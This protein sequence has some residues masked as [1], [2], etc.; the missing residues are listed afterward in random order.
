MKTLMPTLD[1][2]NANISLKHVPELNKIRSYASQFS[3]A[4]AIN[5][6]KFTSGTFAGVTTIII[7]E[8]YTENGETKM[9]LDEVT[10]FNS[11][12]FTLTLGF[13]ASGILGQNI[14]SRRTM[15]I[16]AIT[17][18]T[19]CFTF[20]LS[21]S[22][23]IILIVQAFVG[24]NIP[25]SM[26]PSYAY[27]VEIAEPQL[28]SILLAIGN[29]A[30]IAGSC[31]AVMMAK[32]IHLKTII[33]INTIFPVIGLL[34]VYL[35]PESP[36]W[37]ASKGKLREAEN[38]LL[39]LR[40]WTEP[41][42]IE[43]ELKSLNDSYHDNESSHKTVNSLK[44]TFSPYLTRPFCLPLVSIIYMFFAHSSAGSFTLHAYCIV[45]FKKMD[46][47]FDRYVA[48]ALFDTIRGIGAFVYIFVVP[49][50]GKKKLQF[51]SFITAGFSYSIIAIILLLK[52]K[53][54]VNY[55][56]YSF[57]P[58]V[59]FFMSTFLTSMG[60]FCSIVNYFQ[61]DFA[62]LALE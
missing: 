50:A 1:S 53:E 3:A 27:I 37:L 49:Y 15:L 6:L 60:S 13:L 51:F 52:E 23:T 56:V 47:T 21:T 31:F 19:C 36:H 7:A 54:L 12:C 5:A 38:A 55:H 48:V 22:V 29:L 44:N 14:G 4:W 40:G 2:N 9:T 39:W 10:W 18:I 34:T 32:Y 58:V 41:I 17:Y 46:P 61:Q 25:M 43:S 35:L 24:L 45:I 30:I 26:S 16:A 33:L 28:R 11:Y 20:Y 62:M 42:K 8:F 57:V 59:M